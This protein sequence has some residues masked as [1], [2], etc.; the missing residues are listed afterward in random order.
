MNQYKYQYLFDEHNLN[1]KSL[2]EAKSIHSIA[3]RWV[4][5]PIEHKW[6]FLPNILYDV[7]REAP[8]RINDFQDDMKCGYC[9]ISLFLSQEAAKSKFMAFPKR[10]RDLLGYNSI[11]EG[12][13]TEEDGVV[14]DLAHEHLNFYEFE[15][16]DLRSRFV[17][18]TAM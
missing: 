8:R 17:I 2:E 16:V 13:V 6:N 1:C 18:K 15:D 11:A 14:G 9:A 7:A 3:F 10:I 5:N 12:L 4:I